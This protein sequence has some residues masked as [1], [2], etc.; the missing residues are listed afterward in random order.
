[1]RSCTTKHA[2]MW[3]AAARVCDELSHCAGSRKQAVQEAGVPSCSIMRLQRE[4][5][6]IRLN[7]EPPMQVAG[8]RMT[9][10]SGARRCAMGGG[11]GRMSPADLINLAR[12]AA[13]DH[14]R[15]HLPHGISGLQPARA[16]AAR[17]AFLVCGAPGAACAAD[18]SSGTSRPLSCRAPACAALLASAAGAGGSGGDSGGS[19]PEDEVHT[20]CA[21]AL[22]CSLS[23][24][25]ILCSS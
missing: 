18:S 11:G 24:P 20:A 15:T 17:R 23:I 4:R 19:P 13:L 1:M 3:A 5:V 25:N 7:C 9:V 6:A 8:L 2:V 22:V 14:D 16:R 21:F 12:I 10:P